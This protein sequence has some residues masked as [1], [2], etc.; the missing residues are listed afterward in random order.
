MLQLRHKLQTGVG[1]VVQLPQEVMLRPFDFSDVP[2]LVQA[3]GENQPFLE[4]FLPWATPDYSAAKARQWVQA[5]LEQWSQNLGFQWGLFRE[6]AVLGALG[7]HPIQWDIRSASIGYWLVQSAGR[8][9]LMTAAAAELLEWG[10]RRYRLREMWIEARDTNQPSQRVAE[11]LGFERRGQRSDGESIL[12]RYRL[13]SGAWE[14][15]QTA[16]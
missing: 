1:T 11:R 14:R 12:F 13:L 5:S 9:G 16:R 4:Q 15:R 10:F 7:F 6:H 3:V 2:A 8:Q